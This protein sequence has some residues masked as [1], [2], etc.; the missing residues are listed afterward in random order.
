MGSPR[1]YFCQKLVLRH[2]NGIAPFTGMPAPEHQRR[3]HMPH[4]SIDRAMSIAR[5]VFKQFT[6]LPVAQPFPDDWLAGRWQMP[7]RRSGRHVL[8]RKIMVLMAAAASHTGNTLSIR[9]AP[10]VHGVPVQVVS[11]PGKVST[12]TAIHAS[13]MAEHWEYRLEGRCRLRI[14]AHGLRVGLFS[15]RVFRAPGDRWESPMNDQ[16]TAQS[17]RSPSKIF[18]ATSLIWP[19]IAGTQCSP[20]ALS[21]K[22]HLSQPNACCIKDRIADCCRDDC[23][24]SFARASCRYI[25]TVDERDI[26]GRQFKVKKKTLV[27]FPIG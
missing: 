18:S 27:A 22:R 5:R 14:V 9:A 20:D 15:V 17:R 21:G 24:G 19:H 4:N 13:R 25:W 10:D 12:G 3:I 26:N 11:L 2:R 8:P 6:Q 23:D 16:A 7:V 1:F